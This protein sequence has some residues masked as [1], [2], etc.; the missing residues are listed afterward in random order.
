VKIIEDADI[1][2]DPRK[3][4][5]RNLARVEIQIYVE[6]SD[7]E[8]NKAGVPGWNPAAIDYLRRRLDGVETVGDVLKRIDKYADG[9]IMRVSGR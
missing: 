3:R 2:G 1:D 5:F 9:A 4:S 7:S 8:L 6:I